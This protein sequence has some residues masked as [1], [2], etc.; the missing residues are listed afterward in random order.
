MGIYLKSLLITAI[1]VLTACG[2]GN[3]NSAKLAQVKAVAYI[4]SYAQTGG[5]APT[6]KH[7]VDAGVIGANANNLAKV[8]EA[9]ERLNYDNVDTQSEIQL[10]VNYYGDIEPPVFTSSNTFLIDEY[11]LDEVFTLK[12]KDAN[13][14]RYSIDSNDFSVDTNTGAVRQKWP[15]SYELKDSYTFTAYAR[16]ALGNKG[17]QSV[18]VNLVDKVSKVGYW[19]NNSNKDPYHRI[20]S[21]ASVSGDYAYMTYIENVGNTTGLRVFDVSNPLSPIFKVNHVLGS[22]TGLPMSITINDGYAYIANG[23]AGLQIVD[24][25]NPLSPIN[26]GKIGSSETDFVREVAVE[27][28][29]AYLATSSGLKIID[30]S[31]KEHPIF[32]SKFVKLHITDSYHHVAIKGSYAFVTTDTSNIFLVN[33]SDKRNPILVTSLKTKDSCNKIKIKGDYVYVSGDKGLKIIDIV[34]ISN[35]VVTDA[36]K[37]IHVGDISMGDSYV[38][39][40]GGVSNY[41]GL[42]VINTDDKSN[43]RVIGGYGSDNGVS[44]VFLSNGYAYIAEWDGSLLVLYIDF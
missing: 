7:Y 27:G 39:V 16:D 44:S 22:T 41:G 10:V 8:N 11:L 21:E 13:K 33:I 37:K 5:E 3:N 20:S 23:H 40:S 24:I 1:A 18:T 34:D 4:A 30:I 19:K 9:V 2:G 14:V 35:P 12:A 26:I 32:V 36:V 42:M 43:F 38:V 28:D 29:Y 15:L 31:N 17:S 25:T 6:V